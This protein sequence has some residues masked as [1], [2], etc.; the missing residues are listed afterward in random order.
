MRTTRTRLDVCVCV[1]VPVLPAPGTHPSGQSTTI[2]MDHILRSC[3]QCRAAAASRARTTAAR[4]EKKG[5]LQVRGSGRPEAAPYSTTCSNSVPYAASGRSGSDP[6]P[7]AQSVEFPSASASPEAQF[8]T[9]DTVCRPAGKDQA[10]S[11]GTLECSKGIHPS[12]A[13]TAADSPAWCPK[14]C[15]GA[16]L[17]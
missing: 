15:T 4:E 2:A 3:D 7:A 6:C 9:A 11:M 12:Q 14:N 16:A 17:Q 10:C 13:Y 5:F 1:S 8:T